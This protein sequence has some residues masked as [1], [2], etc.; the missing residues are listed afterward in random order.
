MTAVRQPRTRLA[1]RFL[2]ACLV[3]F[4]GT[5]NVANV[6]ALATALARHY[7]SSL[8]VIGLFTTAC[9]L[10]ELAALIP[11]GVL[12]DRFGPKR[13]GLAGIVICLAGNALLL[14][15]GV[16]FAVAVRFVIGLGVG[17]SFLAGSAYART[18]S[19]SALVQG[20]Y[21]GMSLAAAG[22]ALAIVPQLS[23]SFGWRAPYLSALAIAAVG[24]VL[25]AGAPAT[26]PNRTR[27]PV[28][29]P[30]LAIDRRLA[31]LGMLSTASFGASI[32]IGNWAPTLLARAHGYDKGTAGVI[33]GLTVLLGIVG[34][35]VGGIVTRRA[36]AATRLVIVVSFL[37]AAVA[38]V[39]LALGAPLS[40]MVIAAIAIGIAGG[41]PFG[42]IMFAATRVYPDAPGAAIG[43]MN[44]YPAAAIVVATPLIGLTF[45]LPGN[46]RIGFIVLA[47]LWALAALSAP[48]NTVFR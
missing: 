32:V 7:H 2:A 4:V 1:P 17:T 36:P 26:A 6:G 34:R 30:T 44:V 27:S 20:L 12:I 19:A 11:S 48:P 35:P 42:P 43:A 21:G 13:V 3:G 8:A 5:W 22:C 45:G 24:L 33:A 46:G 29:L 41:T 18:A 39:V 47:A 38:T 40:V 23:N 28:V 10:G 14:L 16:P 15:P 31:H 37:A 25:V 9:F